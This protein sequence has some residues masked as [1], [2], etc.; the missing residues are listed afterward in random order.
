MDHVRTQLPLAMGVALLAMLC[1][2]LSVLL[3]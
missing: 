2:T 1:S 3:L